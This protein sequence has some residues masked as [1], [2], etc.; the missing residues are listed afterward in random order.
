MSGSRKKAKNTKSS[1]KGNAKAKKP[2]QRSFWRR[3][4][5][6]F[7]VMALLLG[8][9]GA[10]A[11]ALT[12]W[13]YSRTLPGIF[14]YDDYRP[15]QMTVIYDRLGVPILE[16]FEERRTVISFDEVPLQMRQAI[17]AAEDAS[18][19][20]HQGLSYVGMIRAV[21]ISIQR[22]SFSQG[23]STITQ[24]VVKNLL[25]TPEKQMSRKIQEALLARQI[26]QALTKDEILAIYLNHVYFGH[27]NYGIEQAA[28]FY[29]GVP[30][31]GLTL[32]QAATLAGVVQ[33]PE[34]LSPRKHP[35][36]A[37]ARR[38]YVL[39]QMRDKGFIN[40]DVFNQTMKEDIV[41]SESHR[42]SLGQAPY[43][44][45]HVRQM[46]VAEYGRD[47]VYNA[48]L[49]VTTSVDLQ[50][51]AMAEK[52]FV[53]GLYALDERRY[54]NRPVKNPSKKAPTK[55]E[56]NQNYEARIVRIE[57]DTVFFSIAG[58][59]LPYAP[60]ARQRRQ[61]PL[62][63]AFE[64][65]QTWFVQIEA[66]AEDRKPSKIFIPSGANGALIAIDPF[67]REVRALVG[68]YSYRESV[69][70]RA[71]QAQ[72]QTGSS[73]KTF[74]YGAG[75]EARVITPSTIIDDAPKVFHI[76]GQAKPWSA[77]NSDNKF[78]GPMTTRAALAQSRNT[79]AVDV[80]ERTGI[81]NTIAF[82]RKFG[83]TSPLVENYTLALGSSEMTLL[84]VTN[85]YA[86][87]ADEG[88]YKSPV[89]ITKI[90]HGHK[91]MPVPQQVTRSAI[92][93]DVA[94][95]LTSMLKSVATD[96]T[97][98]RYLGKWTRDVAGKTGTT[99]DTKDA[100]FVGFTPDLACGIYIGHDEPRNL[101]RGEGGSTTAVP[102][103]A[104]FMAAY[105]KDLSPR[106]FTLPG[107][108]VELEVDAATGLLPRGASVRKEVFLSGTQPTQVA[109]SG[110]DIDNQSWMMRQ[111]DIPLDVE[112]YVDDDSQDAF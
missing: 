98:K 56:K 81:A 77:Q 60:T 107:S 94:Y 68:G 45:E 71:T 20:E 69:F 108:V 41:P 90:E 75:L 34:R 13:Y 79:V 46:L 10:G 66:F 73:F 52:A 104:D 83:I 109:P 65:G 21:V 33:S 78:L 59:E 32:N 22:G 14:S 112:D 58:K 95:V 44:A 24:Q 74:V 62:E 50:A 36:R 100:W 70:N 5:R 93:P 38:N 8:F 26:E 51:Q 89:F 61:R 12:F 28:Q 97:A 84:D 88:T 82:V 40:E 3:L 67:T 53:E 7:V 6:F 30:A 29:F 19:Y 47:Y 96:G 1:A 43:F 54:T 99:N 111:V 42:T 63:E 87:I 39:R 27:R 110:D 106:A 18:F 4:L 105:H 85:A 103:F 31:K 76:Q 92:A 72:R 80:L 11:V 9:L 86:T 101:G 15:K 37:L 23:A 55:F 49:H 25:L 91:V 17:L 102:V 2:S 64:V 48:G 35:E 57:G 16:L